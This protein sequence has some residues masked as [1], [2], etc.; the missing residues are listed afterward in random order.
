LPTFIKFDIEGFELKA[1]QGASRLLKDVKP[2]L[3]IS[4]YHYP[5]D[6]IEIYLYLVNT[7][8]SAK[9]YLRHYSEGTDET[10]LFCIPD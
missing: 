6:L 5:L 3:A 1:L 9:Y 4:I 8:K 2:K 7:F 10:V